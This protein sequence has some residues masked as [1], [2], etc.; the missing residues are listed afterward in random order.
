MYTNS[1]VF[2][3]NFSLKNVVTVDIVM[4]MN[5]SFV[6][7]KEAQAPRWHVI[8]ATDQVLG[9]LCSRVADLLRGKDKPEFTPH[10]DAGDYVIITNCEKI[11]LTGKK[12]TDKMYRQ[13]TGYRSGLKK[14]AARDLHAKDPRLLIEKGVHGMLPK[15]T[16]NRAVLKKLKVYVGSEHPHAAQIAGFSPK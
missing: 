2:E 13:Y 7:K 12:W 5:K 10:S 3:L 1:S 9:R 16:L 4:D 14:V 15:N 6:L 11:R 8:D